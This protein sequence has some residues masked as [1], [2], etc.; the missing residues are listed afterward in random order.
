[1]AIKVAERNEETNIIFDFYDTFIKKED[2]ETINF[3]II[4]KSC[5]GFLKLQLSKYNN[6]KYKLDKIK[7]KKDEFYVLAGTYISPFTSSLIKSQYVSG[8]ILDTTRSLFQNYVSSIPTVMI[9]N[10]G[11]PLGFTFGLVENY[12]IYDSFFETFQNTFGFKITEDILIA[13]SDQGVAL[14]SFVKTKGMQYRI[15]KWRRNLFKQYK[16]FF[17]FY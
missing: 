1:M 13:E 2:Y 11:Q 14:K 9:Q 15:N 6:T 17:F 16:A 7:I 12:E 4:K 8:I 5:E 3:E 10:V